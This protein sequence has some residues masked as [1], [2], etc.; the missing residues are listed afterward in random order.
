MAPVIVDR[1]GIGEP[2]AGKNKPLL[3]RQI[4]DV[5]DAPE[6]LGMQAAS[7][8]ARL[9]QPRNLIRRDRSI[10]D[11]AGRGLDLDERL[12][13]KEAARTCAHNRHIDAAAARLI[14]N[15][16]G[17]GVRANRQRRRIGRNENARAH[18][19]FRWAPATSASRRSRSRRPIGSPSMSA[20]GE[21]AQ[22][23]RQ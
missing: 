3:P 8:E 18:C 17:D 10:A 2:T 13:P 15:R 12:E 11:A 1:Q 5:L 23:P 4:G 7:Q 9:E 21:R 16:A 22:L 20:A 6:R 19:I 14:E